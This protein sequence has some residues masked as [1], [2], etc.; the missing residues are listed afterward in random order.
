MNIFFSDR[1]IN[2]KDI[3]N[4]YR[5]IIT[6]TSKNIAIILLPPIMTPTPVKKILHIIFNIN[7]IYQVQLKLIQFINYTHMN[8]MRILYTFYSYLPCK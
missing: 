2:D 5:I 1:K 4:Y 7:F 8:I 3:E 6:A